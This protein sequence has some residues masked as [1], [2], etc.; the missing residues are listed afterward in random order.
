MGV[1]KNVLY[2]TFLTGA[3]YIFPL[4]TYP[5]ISRVL[6]PENI[7][8]NEFALRIV[9]YFLLFASLGIATVGTR[10]IAKC[11]P[12]KGRPFKNF[13]FYFGPKYHIHHIR[14]CIILHLY[15]FGGPISKSQTSASH[16]INTA[17]IYP[18]LNRMAL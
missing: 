6:G 4:I 10:E 15:L 16:R 12:I 13:F 11:K 5:Y 1:K 8:E 3:N 14:S 7:G 9:G 18:I 2:S 17:C